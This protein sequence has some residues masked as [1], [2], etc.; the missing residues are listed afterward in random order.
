MNFALCKV[1]LMKTDLEEFSSTMDFSTRLKEL[2][3]D[4]DMLQSDLAEKLNL[5]SSAISKYE[6]GLTQPS[7]ETIKKLAE[8]FSVTIDYLV[9]ASDIKNPYDVNRI[10]PNEADL[11]DRFRRLS[12][13]NKIRIDERIKTMIENNSI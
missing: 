3:T 7:I 11:V 1:F 5:K 2:R 9:G 10:T 4:N 6:K 8:I 12:Y 13:E